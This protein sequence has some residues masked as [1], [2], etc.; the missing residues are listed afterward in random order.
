MRD[1]LT[2]KAAIRTL[3]LVGALAA[4]GVAYAA[5]PSMASAAPASETGGD[6]RP[7]AWGEA[8]DVASSGKAPSLTNDVGAPESGTGA[9]S[10]LAAALLGLGMVALVYGLATQAGKRL[11][12]PTPLNPDASNWRP[13]GHAPAETR[14]RP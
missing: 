5:I 1:K 14:A 10:A 6:H 12:G 4:I 9:Q 3:A 11:R 13:A 8:G 2:S 7:S